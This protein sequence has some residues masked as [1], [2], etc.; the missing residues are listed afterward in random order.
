MHE[1]K[2]R[3]NYYSTTKTKKKK[4]VFHTSFFE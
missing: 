3:L 1:Y 2:P 4:G